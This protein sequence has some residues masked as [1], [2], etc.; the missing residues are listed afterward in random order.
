MRTFDPDRL[1]PASIL[2]NIPAMIAET[3]APF[4][5]PEAKFAVVTSRPDEGVKLGTYGV[6][7]GAKH[8]IALATPA[9]SEA[10]VAASFRLE[11]VL[12]RLQSMGLGY[13]WVGGTFR[14]SDFAQAAELSSEM[15]IPVVVP[16]GYAKSPRLLERVMRATSRA[17][18]RKS[19]SDLFFLG[20]PKQPLTPEQAGRMAEAL[21]MVRLAPS[22]YNSQPWRVVVDGDKAYFYGRYDGADNAMKDV[23]MGIALSHFSLALAHAG[24]EHVITPAS[25]VAAPDISVP[26]D[27]HFVATVTLN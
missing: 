15:T 4:Q 8:F 7:S 3:P 13:V 11:S 22:D 1:I 26:S 21:E 16:I 5:A 27:W 23:D 17:S 25:E 20:S 9:M 10:I 24:V 6:I 2:D 19:W 12:L 18:S 14:R